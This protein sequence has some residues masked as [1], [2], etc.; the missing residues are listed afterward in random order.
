MMGVPAYTHGYKHFRFVTY[1]RIYLG[2]EPIICSYTMQD[3]RSF[4]TS[5]HLIV[6]EVSTDKGS[7]PSSINLITHF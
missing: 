3:R 6:T 5:I 4:L 7:L 1:R 2:I